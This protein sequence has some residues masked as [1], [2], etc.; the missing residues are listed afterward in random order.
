MNTNLSIN[1]I[2][3]FG[4]EKEKI[5]HVINDKSFP[6]KQYNKVANSSGA[7]SIVSKSNPANDL[8]NL[9][10]SMASAKSPLMNTT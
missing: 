6:L 4:F 5:F 10:N 9:N 2:V 7:S 1:E 3:E 8:G